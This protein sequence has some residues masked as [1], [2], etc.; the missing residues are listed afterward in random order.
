MSV[1][2]DKRTASALPQLPGGALALGQ[3]RRGSEG[4]SGVPFPP[5]FLSVLP[6]LSH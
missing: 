4:G 5:S 6:P 3:K 2:K 1:Q